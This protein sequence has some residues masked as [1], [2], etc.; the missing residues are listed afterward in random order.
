MTT[1]Y[2]RGRAI[3]YRIQ[4]ELESVGYTTAR[5]AGSKGKFDVLA[6]DAIHFRIIQ[7]KSFI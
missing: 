4:R 5:A 1:R 2:E 7:A 6:W 3:E